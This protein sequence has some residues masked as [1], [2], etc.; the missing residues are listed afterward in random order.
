MKNKYYLIGGLIAIMVS[1]IGITSLVSA[2]QRF[3]RGDSA[4]EMKGFF[5][6]KRQEMEGERQAMFENYNVWAAK[7]NE[8][9]TDLEKRAQEIRTNITQENFDKLSQI[10]KLMQEGNFE[11]A[12]KLREES[13]FQGMGMG[14]K[15]GPMRGFKN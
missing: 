5:Q 4:A 14:L 3:K 15:M 10:N 8:M 9:A 12:K 6:E 1:V 2:N 13:G 11:E 7:M